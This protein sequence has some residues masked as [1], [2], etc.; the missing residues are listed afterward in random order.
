MGPSPTL[1]I[2]ELKNANAM[3]VYSYL[4]DHDLGLAPN[5]T[6][7]YCT[8]AVCKPEIRKSN[9][10]TLGDWVIGTGSKALEET[11]GR[12]LTN[13]LIYAMKVT[14]KI[15]LESYWDDSRFQYK[16]PIMNGP[17]ST[18]FGDNFYH[19]DQTGNWF[20]EDSSHSNSDGSMNYEHLRRD[21]EGR[22]VLISEHFYYFGNNAP[23]I[24]QILIEVC[25]KT[26]G[27][28]I[29]V[30]DQLA[31]DFIKWVSFNFHRGIHGDP[32]NWDEY[33]QLNLF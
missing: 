18:M 7:K 2:N 15:S 14:D 5:P 31:V 17:L 13:K 25:H 20:Q 11:T 9:N 30:P 21:T 19:K 6:G 3:K 32:L 12:K 16:K 28:K 4:L 22:N 8:L 29:V 1:F 23:I 26:Q 33:N 10:L 27:Q 24:P